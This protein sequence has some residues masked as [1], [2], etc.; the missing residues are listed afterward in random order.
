M[1]LAVLSVESGLE[2]HMASDHMVANSLAQAMAEFI[3]RQERNVLSGEIAEQLAK[4]LR[5]EQHLLACAYQSPEVARAQAGLEIVADKK[6][7]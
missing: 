3:T 2:T 4:V 1:A 7:I 5:A 6:L